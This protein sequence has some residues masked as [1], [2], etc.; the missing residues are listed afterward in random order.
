MAFSGT[1][2]AAVRTALAR[3]GVERLVLSIHQASFP[4]SDDDVGYGTPYSANSGALLQWLAGLGFSGVSLGPAGITSRTNPSPYDSTALSRNPLHIALGPLCEQGLLD[5][6]LLAAAVAERPSGERVAYDYAW[7][8]QHRLLAAVAARTRGDVELAQ[9]LAQLRQA[10]PW[11]DAEARFEAI[12]AAEGHDDWERWPASPAEQPGAAYQFLLSQL[13]VHEQ[14]AAFRNHARQL[15]IRVYCDL[16]IGTSQRDRFFFGHLFLPHYAMGAPP[17]RTNPAG[18]PWGYPVLDPG[19][20]GA[21]GEAWRFVTMR[22]NAVLQDHDGLRIDHPHG[23]VCPWV[24][25]TDDPHPLHAVQH[26]ARLYE[27]PDLPDHPTLVAYARIR[28]DQIDRSLPRHADHWVRE[29]EPAQIQRYA[30]PFELILKQVREHGGQPCDLMAEVL[31]TCPQPLAEVLA[32]YR[33][34][35]YRVTQKADVQNPHDV[36]RSDLARPEDWIMAG[37]HDTL[38]VC[39]VLDTW[40]HTGE[41]PRRAEYLAARLAANLDERAVLAARFAHDRAALTTAMFADLFCGPAR[42]VLIFWADLFALREAY[43]RPGVI[44]QTNWS[45]RV[46]ADF[47]R[48]YREAHDGKGILAQALAWALHARGLDQ[49][50][51]G[52]ALTAALLKEP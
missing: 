45:L 26:G 6:R 41:V 2:Q 46:A 29:I 25:R 50:A 21:D 33:I 9:R 35:R 14:H 47:E 48:A 43:N 42:N 13:L 7:N 51:E 36:Y 20:L 5:E 18:Q 1:F 27:S 10:A 4:A 16:P 39:A 15:G 11:L 19:K 44:D 24:Y 12:A 37:N 23:W 17:S 30:H 38:P 31:S 34:G 49:D 28:S 32:R 3:L 40:Q 52:Q 22:L 8:T